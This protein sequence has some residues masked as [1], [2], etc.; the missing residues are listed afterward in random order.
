MLDSAHQNF[1]QR[2]FLGSFGRTLLREIFWGWSF[3]RCNQ[4]H[5]KRLNLE[6]VWIPYWTC[7]AKVYL[8]NHKRG[9]RGLLGPPLNS[10]LKKKKQ[11]NNRRKKEA[12]AQQQQ[13]QQLKSTNNVCLLIV[14]KDN[15]SNDYLRSRR[16]LCSCKRRNAS[17]KLLLAWWTTR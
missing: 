6:I 3:L 5:S 1:E 4:V 8:I 10:A 15:F 12:P 13:Q 11:T 9:S 7:N 14:L 2:T 16:P 17:Y